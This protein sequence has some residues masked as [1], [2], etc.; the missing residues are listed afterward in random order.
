M[1]ILTFISFILILTSCGSDSI[2]TQ[3][4]QNDSTDTIPEVIDSLAFYKEKLNADPSNPAVIYERAEYYIRHAEVELAQKDL[5]SIL[6]KDS[7]NLK[8]HQLYADINLANLNLE[9]S[10]YHYE[11]IL[12][13]D[14]SKTGAL[15]GMGK[16]YAAL[17]NSPVALNYLSAALRVNQY[18]PEPYFTKG[19]IYRSDYYRRAEEDPRK[20]ESWERAMSS[21]QTAVEQDPDY[22]A[23]YIEMGVMFEEKG[24]SISLEYYNT[25]IDIFPQSIEAWY[26]K[27]MYYQTRG[28][29]DN[30]LSSY[31]TLNRLDDTW[32]DPYYNIGYIHLIMT[33]ELDSAVHYFTR[34]TELDPTYYQAYNNLGLAYEKKGDRVNAKKYYLRAVEINP[35][36][37]LAKDNL[38]AVQ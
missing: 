38:N 8:A 19:L 32:A 30:A 23:A 31:Y 6:A 2:Q 5:E 9:T 4:D 24:D 36:F 1:R 27:G 29:V 13:I 33:E 37:Q 15:I 11:Y 17:D 26:N 21:F 20:E 28:Y 25:A 18:L 10:K 7:S 12:K 35:D 3:D 34:A 16:I 22:Y 14:S